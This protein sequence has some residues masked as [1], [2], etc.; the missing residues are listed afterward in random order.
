MS[1]I[2][3][4]KEARGPFTGFWHG[5]VDPGSRDPGLNALEIPGI[6]DRGATSRLRDLTQTRVSAPA[7]FFV[8]DSN[9]PVRTGGSRQPGKSRQ[10]SAKRKR[11]GQPDRTSSFILMV[12]APRSN[13]DFVW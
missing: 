1:E 9:M 8:A 3:L 10:P 7:G 13:V 5:R 6:L 2:A 11:R 12:R 4:Y